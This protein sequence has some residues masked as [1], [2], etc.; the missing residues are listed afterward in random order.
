MLISDTSLATARA[1]LALLHS[2]TAAHSRLVATT[3]ASGASD[4]SWT[5]IGD[6]QCRIETNMG[7]RSTDVVQG[8]PPVD[9]P[10][11]EFTVFAA[12]DADIRLGDRL[13]A[14]GITMTVMQASR[15]QSQAF[16]SAFDC[17]EVA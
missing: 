1:T 11:Y 13:T 6:V 16:V 15:A 17:S 10:V 5:P 14:N 3:S 9:R 4:R 7:D 2:T 8:P 12:H